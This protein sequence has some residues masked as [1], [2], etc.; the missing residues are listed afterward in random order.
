MQLGNISLCLSSGRWVLGHRTFADGLMGWSYEV[1]QYV[2]VR[3]IVRNFPK[4]PLI[5]FR[6]DLVIFGEAM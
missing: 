4:N 5:H 1:I 6:D 3:T 2:H